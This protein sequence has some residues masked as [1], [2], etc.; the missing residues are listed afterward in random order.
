MRSVELALPSDKTLIA[1][2]EEARRLAAEARLANQA[3]F[4]KEAVAE[5][6][7]AMVAA[8]VSL[9]TKAEARLVGLA[10]R[11][12]AGPPATTMSPAAALA[13]AVV[14]T[15]WL[16]R[17]PAGVDSFLLGCLAGAPLAWPG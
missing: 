13:L 7:E 9:D 6:S 1:V 3:G 11:A 15:L 5:V 17:W 14:V 12:R 10:G 4:V 2:R 16:A 8:V